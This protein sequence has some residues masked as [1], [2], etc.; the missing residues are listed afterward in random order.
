MWP[1]ALIAMTITGILFW[2]D[3][4]P[5]AIVASFI[6]FLVFTLVLTSKWDSDE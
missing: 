6:G 2:V 5:D 1:E 3:S 4:H